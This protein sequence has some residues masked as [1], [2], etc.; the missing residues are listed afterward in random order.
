MYSFGT[1]YD[2]FR[3]YHDKIDNINLYILEALK[4]EK[5]TNDE[6]SQNKESEIKDFFP[7]E[8]NVGNSSIIIQETKKYISDPIT[9]N[10]EKKKQE[11]KVFINNK[12]NHDKTFYDSNENILEEEEKEK[13]IK[14]NIKEKENKKKKEE[15]RKRGRR[16]KDVEYNIKP[17]HDKFHEDN[18]IKKIKLNVFDYILEHL[19]KSLKDDTYTF[20]SLSKQFYDNIKKDFNEQ[21]IDRTIYDI[22]FNTD[23]SKK[24]V[25]APDSN[26]ILI[27][28][29]YE[30]NTEVDTK[31]ILEMKFR[32]ILD[33]IREK[34]L[35]CFLKKIRDKEIKNNKQFNDIYMKAVKKMLFKY[36]FY[37]KLKLG[38]NVK[39]KIKQLK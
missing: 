11:T 10:L 12:R 5:H 27:K 1:Y 39:K 23:L 15:K 6:L 4:E 31:H 8:N 7:K 14:E 35:D 21:L 19:N 9:F 30:E 18:I 34:D 22:Y 20:F 38:R 28:K 17:R 13:N 29:I 3:D 33:Q 24:Y 25:N 26:K 16:R 32:D 2:E 36:E 37:F